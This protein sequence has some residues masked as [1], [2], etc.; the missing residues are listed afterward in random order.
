MMKFLTCRNTKGS[1]NYVLDKSKWGKNGF[2]LSISF[3]NVIPDDGIRETSMQHIQEVLPCYHKTL[4]C[5]KFDLSKKGT[6]RES[7]INYIVDSFCY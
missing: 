1:K 3:I 7:L 2:E 5:P 6:G 4:F